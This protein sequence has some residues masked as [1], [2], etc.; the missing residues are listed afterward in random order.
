MTGKAALVI[1]PEWSRRTMEILDLASRS[2]R[3]NRTLT[4]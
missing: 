3:E 4:A 1:T 2:A